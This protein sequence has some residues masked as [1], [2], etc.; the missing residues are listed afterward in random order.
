[1]SPRIVAI[2][3]KKLECIFLA[4]GFRFERQR[5]D[6]R[7]HVKDGCARPVVIPT[8]GKIDPDNILANMRT[9]GMGREEYFKLLKEC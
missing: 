1:V 2:H 7:C 6:H 4:A 8:Y 9:A 5:G 3:W